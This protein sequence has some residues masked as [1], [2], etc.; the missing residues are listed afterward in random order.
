[1]ERKKDLAK[2]IMKVENFKEKKLI[3]RASSLVLIKNTAKMGQ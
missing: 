1:M 3:K 2:Y